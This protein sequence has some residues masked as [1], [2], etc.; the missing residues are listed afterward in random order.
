[1]YIIQNTFFFYRSLR[2]L[3]VAMGGA[4]IKKFAEYG[5]CLGAIFFCISDSCLAINKFDVYYLDQ[6]VIMITYYLAQLGITLSIVR[7]PGWIEKSK[8]KAS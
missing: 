2:D 7:H 4:D 1:M 8:L 5:A 3:G 6:K